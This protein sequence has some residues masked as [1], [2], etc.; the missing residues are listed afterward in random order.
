M[1]LPA[2]RGLG[3]KKNL[4]ERIA[5]LE[6]AAGVQPLRAW[7]AD[8]AARRGPDTVIP[9]FDPADAGVN[10]RVMLLLEAPGPKTV[11]QWGGSGFISSDNNDV[12]A[13]NAWRARDAAGLDKNTVAWNIVPWLLGR[14][15]VHPN[16]GQLGQGARELRQLLP[17]FTDLQCVVLCGKKA[18]KGWNDHVAPFVGDRYTVIPTWHPSAQSFAQPGKRDEFGAALRRAAVFAR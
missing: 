16:V 18:E 2:P 12:T 6:T 7:S 13:E 9:D 5:M 1:F 10:A 14:A 17:I 15:N 3:I 11:R 8:L 4:D